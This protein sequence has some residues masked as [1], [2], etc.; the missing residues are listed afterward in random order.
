MRK[1]ALKEKIFGNKK[2]CKHIFCLVAF[3]RDPKDDLDAHIKRSG[4]STIRLISK[5]LVLCDSQHLFEQHDTGFGCE[6]GRDTSKGA[7]K[8]GTPI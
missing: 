2:F 7:L 5:F 8:G 3:K 4:K 6:Q 1:I